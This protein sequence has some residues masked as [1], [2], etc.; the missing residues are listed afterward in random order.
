MVEYG[1]I[2]ESN[3]IP[4]VINKVWEWFLKFD[5]SEND[6][7]KS[8]SLLTRQ[9]RDG[10]EPRLHLAGQLEDILLDKMILKG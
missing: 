9:N 8:R 1:Y 6:F 7:Q 2:N 4:L 3:A 10:T 5:I